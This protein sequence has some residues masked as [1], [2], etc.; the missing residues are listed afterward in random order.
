MLL[1]IYG[2]NSINQI[3]SRPFTDMLIEFICLI[4]FW[5]IWHINYKRKRVIVKILFRYIYYW[6]L[7]CNIYSNLRC[8][9]NEYIFYAM[10]DN[11]C[12]SNRTAADKK[13]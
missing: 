3:K 11:I 8:L 13:W 4:F 6:C 1:L 10:L 5:Y 12:T 2:Y 7:A 9:M